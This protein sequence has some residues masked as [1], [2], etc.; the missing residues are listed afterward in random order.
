[1]EE[2]KIIPA[3]ELI[4]QTL[5]DKSVM[6]QVIFD[7]TLVSFGLIKEV[8]HEI[9][10][11]YN[12]NLKGTDR[13]I[14][15]EYVDRGK[16]EAEL[17]VAG[18]ILIFSMHSNVFEFDRDHSIWKLSYVQED[19]MRSYCGIISIYNFLADSFR[20]N[21]MED[22]GYLIGR[23]FINKDSHYFLEGKRQLGF[24]YNNFGTT[25]IDKES[26]RKMIETAIL[27][28]LEFDL[29]VPPYDTVKIASVGQVNNKIENS[30]LQTG[31]RLGYK[32]N[33]DDVLEEK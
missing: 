22:L 28:T 18:D 11:D 21:R 4:I 23:I 2:K 30:K 20:Y 8:L 27:Y 15:L 1:M 7:N 10:T 12:V 13:R 25:E 16:F 5:A 32:F 29:L 33:S 3:K 31:K 9:A 6:K 19:K 24:L 17:K 26:I 14:R